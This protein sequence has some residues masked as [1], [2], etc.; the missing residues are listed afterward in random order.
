MYRWTSDSVSGEDEQSPHA[1]ADDGDDVEEQ[2]GRDPVPDESPPPAPPAQP[3]RAPV[4]DVLE[5]LLSERV[6]VGT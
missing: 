1:D 2:Q 5:P 3:D 6:K 4:P